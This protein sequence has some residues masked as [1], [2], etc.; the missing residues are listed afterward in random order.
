MFTKEEIETIKYALINNIFDISDDLGLLV[1]ESNL[2]SKTVNELCKVL[3][4][5]YE[6]YNK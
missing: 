5:L 2:K 6:I 4:Y 1:N 3:D